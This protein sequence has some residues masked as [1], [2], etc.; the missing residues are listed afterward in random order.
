MFIQII[1]TKETTVAVKPQW[2]PNSQTIEDGGPLLI[3]KYITTR[4][5]QLKN[6]NMKDCVLVH[7]LS[8]NKVNPKLQFIDYGKAK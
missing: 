1:N 7:S 4:R 2:D 3:H 5:T 8:K 6:E